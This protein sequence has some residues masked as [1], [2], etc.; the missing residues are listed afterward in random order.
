MAYQDSNVRVLDATLT[1]VGRRKLA[2]GDLNV[3]YFA[4]F[5]DEVDYRLYDEDALNGATS[6]KIT[7]LPLLEATPTALPR[8]FLVDREPRS[9]DLVIDDDDIFFPDD[10][11]RPPIPPSPSS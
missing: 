1:D 9:L 11:P 5:D 2:A 8:Y 3:R 6:T 4:L 7:N 10:P